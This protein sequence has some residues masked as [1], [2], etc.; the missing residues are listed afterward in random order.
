MWLLHDYLHIPNQ[1]GKENEA[2]DSK[3]DAEYR[4][5]RISTGLKALSKCTEEAKMTNANY[6]DKN[7]FDE[8]TWDAKAC[9]KIPKSNGG[10]SSSSTGQA[11][12]KK[13]VL[14]LPLCL[15]ALCQQVSLR[16]TDNK[17]QRAP[18]IWRK[19]KKIYI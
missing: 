17:Y 2:K 8:T 11:E 4:L 3:C 19:N 1:Q 15:Q 5:P 18:T 9:L 16:S 14:Q 13:S 10:L 6:L 12:Y 7:L